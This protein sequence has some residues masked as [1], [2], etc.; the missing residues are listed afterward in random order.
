MDAKSRIN[1]KDNILTISSTKPE[2]IAIVI[3]K[4]DPRPDSRLLRYRLRH[5]TQ[6]QTQITSEMKPSEKQSA[7][8]RD[9]IISDKVTRIHGDASGAVTRRGWLLHGVECE[10]MQDIPASSL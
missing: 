5:K 1:S 8:F 3:S 9:A 2:S 6:N 7:R 4:L 10:Q